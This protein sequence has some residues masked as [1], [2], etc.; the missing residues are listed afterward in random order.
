MF[1]AASTPPDARNR[2]LAAAEARGARGG[3]AAIVAR[4]NW[5]PPHPSRRRCLLSASSP[6]GAP[7]ESALPAR[8]DRDRGGSRLGGA[9]AGGLAEAL[10]LAG[11]LP[12]SA[13]K[14]LGERARV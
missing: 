12:H 5:N 2:L 7:L 8:N 9:A 11:V 10:L 4:L 13:A 14:A 1:A 3:L 6:R